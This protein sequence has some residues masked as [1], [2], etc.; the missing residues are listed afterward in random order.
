MISKILC[1]CVQDLEQDRE[2][3]TQV[4]GRILPEKQPHVLTYTNIRQEDSPIERQ[5]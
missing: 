4:F 1:T 3:S 5:R 2:C